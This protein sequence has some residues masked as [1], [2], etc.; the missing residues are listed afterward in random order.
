MENKLWLY[1]KNYGT[2]I[3]YGK[4]YGT[5]LKTE[6]KIFKFCQCIFTISKFLPFQKG[7]GPLPKD[8][9]CQVWLK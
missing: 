1:G 7:L 4:N 5:I 3:Y 8:T 2:L 9:L 6:K